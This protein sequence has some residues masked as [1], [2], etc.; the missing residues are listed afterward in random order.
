MNVL[1]NNLLPTNTL[2][3]TGH[4]GNLNILSSVGRTSRAKYLNGLSE[5]DVTTLSRHRDTLSQEGTT[6]LD[7]MTVIDLQQMG[8]THTHTVRHTHTHTY[9]TCKHVGR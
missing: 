6:R 5:S 9:S 2:E 1:I 3:H 7:T 4:H 8:R